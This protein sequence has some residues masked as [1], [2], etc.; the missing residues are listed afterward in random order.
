MREIKTPPSLKWLIKKRARLHGE[1][2][3]LIESLPRQQK[4][5][6]DNIRLVEKTLRTIDYSIRMQR[7]SCKKIPELKKQI[8]AL[9]IILGIHEVKIDISLIKPTP[10]LTKGL[11][12]QVP[13]GGLT[14]TILQCLSEAPNATKGT[15]EI[16]TYIAVKYGLNADAHN[17]AELKR[18][19]RKRLNALCRDN[20]VKR[21]HSLVT[22]EE[23]RWMLP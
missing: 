14:K 5:L 23:G 21:T 12:G 3:A 8:D 20:R 11:K 16:A 6:E 7:E 22:S 4:I 17:L 19:T 13:H 18:Y 1:L 2:N 9:D 10:S 15:S